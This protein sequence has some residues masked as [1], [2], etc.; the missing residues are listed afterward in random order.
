M[1]TSG[2]HVNMKTPRVRSPAGRTNTE[3]SNVGFSCSREHEN[4]AL[5][6]LEGE[7]RRA[8]R[9][10]V[11]TSHG[12]VAI[13]G[14]EALGPSEVA[15]VACGKE[16]PGRPLWA[17][18]GR[19]AGAESFPRRRTSS[20]PVRLVDVGCHAMS[21]TDA[22][23]MLEFKITGRE[24]VF[25][26]LVERYKLPLLNYFY[27]LTWDRQAAEDC[28]Q[29]VFCRLFRHRKRYR[30]TASLAT[31]LYRIGRNLWIDR[32]RSTRNVPPAVSLDAE[33]SE[34]G[35]PLGAV[36]SDGGSDPSHG[37]EVQDEFRRV[38]RALGSL[39]PELRDA[40]ILVKYQG[41]KYAEAAE[42]MDVPIGTI[43]SRIH[44]AL[45]QVRSILHVLGPPAADRQ[46]KNDGD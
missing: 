12:P 45:E 33:V 9:K 27:K 46:G 10:C 22:E 13:V 42:V 4:P 40:L 23:L 29:E 1:G 34:S 16:L 5:V 17:E 18:I 2:V 15:A 26:E 32:Y 14:S 31:Y 20:G 41:L 7:N 39:A 25:A 37:P 30:P 8:R 44:A 3:A 11:L 36:V 38:R 43:R 35:H 21:K 28:C 19:A 6:P 24:E